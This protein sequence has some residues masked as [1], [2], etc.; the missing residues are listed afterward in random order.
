MKKYIKLSKATE[1]AE[2]SD[3][4]NEKK[5]S[6]TGIVTS[7]SLNVREKASVD[8]GIVTK[9]TANSQV[10]IIAETDDFYKIQLNSK[11][12]YVKK[13]FIRLQSNTS[14]KSTPTPTVKTVSVG[15][16]SK[17]GTVTSQTL[18]MRNDP[19]TDSAIVSVIPANTTLKLIGET[20]DFYQTTYNGR[21]GYVSK[22]YIKI[23]TATERPV[24]TKTA[25]APVVVK[26]LNE[27]GQ[28]TVDTL[29]VRK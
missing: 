10:T 14:A 25:S 20:N 8:S 17:T 1:K 24:Q 27:A 13:S 12:G 6:A 18:N 2:Q 23:V 26:A 28:I 21:S 3:K 4:T 5:L 15:K 29:N 16:I 7:D 11:A 9:L 19:T 22:N